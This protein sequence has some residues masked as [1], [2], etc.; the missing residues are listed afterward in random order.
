M[1]C[2]CLRHDIRAADSPVRYCRG[3]FVGEEVTNYVERRE[4]A[5]ALLNAMD[6]PVIGEILTQ[7][8]SL[9]EIQQRI[10]NTLGLQH[11]VVPDRQKLLTTTIQKFGG[12]R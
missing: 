11:L 1:V 2:E 5:V 9:P 7:I 3:S 4:S 10:A 12:G 6:H 8:L